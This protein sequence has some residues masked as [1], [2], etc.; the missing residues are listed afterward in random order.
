MPTQEELQKGFKLG[1]W[2]V[3][4]AQGVL[5]SGDHEERPEPKV[6]RVLLALA[7]RDGDLVSRDELIDEVWDGRPTSDE[8]INRCLSQLRGH[9]GDKERPHRY[10]E[11]LARRGYRLNKKVELQT[12]VA[13]IP[14]PED[15]VS[16]A[17]YQ[18]GTW[19]LLAVV[20][21]GALL[22]FVIGGDDDG[23]VVK[24]I[25]VLPFEN[26]GRDPDDDYLVTGFKEELV[27]TL[28]KLPDFS[29]K[30]GR[31]VYPDL[32]STE[33][34]TILGVDAV[35]FGAVQ[36]SGDTLKIN[37]HIARAS[38]GIDIGAGSVTGQ[39][40]EI[41]VLQERLAGQVRDFL[42][43]DSQQQLISSSRPANFEAYDR[44]IRGQYALALRG[45]ATNLEDG[46]ALLREAIEIDPQFGPAYL[47][48]ATAYSLLPDYRDAP[49]EET[50]RLAIQTVER[51]IAVDESIRDAA[52]A[53]TGFV[54][55][56]RKEW[57][58]A[59]QA[60]MRAITAPVV[61][62]NAFNWY[63]RMLAAVGRRS[64][65][66]HL[67]LQAQRMDPSSG[68]I[69]TR[70]AS[71]YVWV[72]DNER[73]AEFLERANRLGARSL[74]YLLSSALLHIR[75][76][77]IEAAADLMAVAESMSGRDTGWIGPV[78][79]AFENTSKRAA[80]IAALDSAAVAG[81]MDPRI[82]ITLRAM[83]SDLDGAMLVANRVAQPGA[84]FEVDVLFLPELRD[85]RRRPDF[86]DLM[87]RL[88]IRS[89]WDENQCTWQ[90]DEVSCPESFL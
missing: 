1:D 74:N 51:G 72:G 23:D 82:E 86:M 60:Y 50:H 7:S 49:L 37:F 11:T 90:G 33:I 67:A 78:F 20:V 77:R 13:D 55:H 52:N 48:L 14:V 65:A 71:V 29:V 39:L 31:V 19:M 81:Q 26:L 56:K 75:D 15:V 5:R 53:V 25:A 61:D 38:D 59:E 18:G 36:R 42:Q 17:R 69:N 88:G 30:H 6:F 35:L 47:S 45:S 83:L 12:I 2:E 40:E 62:P 32:E 34:A 3:L 24:S 73:A 68:V 70:A 80:A 41:F 66:L 87:D 8:P 21:V 84:I 54:Y 57:S 89:Y 64:D 27:Q 63:S 28:Y 16:R 4:P 76:G 44:Y 22:A 10:I 85:L 58:K 46:I 79:A 43:V 9:L